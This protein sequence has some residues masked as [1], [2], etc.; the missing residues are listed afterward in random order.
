MPLLLCGACVGRLIGLL[1]LSVSEVVCDAQHPQHLAPHFLPLLEWLEH[2]AGV[3]GLR[4]CHWSVDP[5]NYALIGA[6][7]MLAGTVRP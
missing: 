6:G 5:A 4:E 7:A 3:T 2:E 1:M